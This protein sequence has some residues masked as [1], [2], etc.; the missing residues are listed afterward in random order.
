MEKKKQ[1][2]FSNE[3]RALLKKGI[4]KVADSVK[5]TLGAKGRNVIID[6]F[7]FP[8]VTKDGVT[9]AGEINLEHPIENMGARLIKQVAYQTANDSGDGTTT[10]TLL[11]QVVSTKG[12]QAIEDGANPIEVKKGMDKAVIEIVNTLREKSQDISADY[13]ILK[14]I[15]VISANGDEEIGHLVADVASRVRVDGLVT[16]EQS[17][18]NETYSEVVEGTKILSGYINPYYITNHAKM[19]CEYNDSVVFLYDGDLNTQKDFQPIIVEYEALKT[20]KP[21][22]IFTSGI[23]GEALSFFTINKVKGNLQN[24]PIRLHGKPHEKLELLKDIQS[25]TGGSIISQTTGLMMKDFNKTMFGSL[26]RIITDD[27][28][29]IITN[30]QNSVEKRIDEIKEQI[31]STKEDE[32]KLQQL[33]GRVA[34]LSGGVAVISVGGKTEAEML[35]RKD[36]IDDAVGATKAAMEEGIIAGGG[37]ALFRAKLLLPKVKLPNEDQQIGWDIVLN[38]LDAPIRQILT[39][40]GYYSERQEEII[41]KVGKEKFNFGFDI[42]NEEVVD[43][44]KK[45]IIDPFKVVRNCIE[46]STS[47]AGLIITTECV[48]NDK[49]E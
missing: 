1:I 22:V 8:H 3:G 26:D 30:E 42:L 15:A 32:F 33:R 18:T 27:K 29:T 37:V 5:V 2:T 4:D 39:N 24:I 41:N 21:L 49:E 19:R 11:A 6:R 38:S 34:R 14:Q 13:D 12:L 46:N 25:I 45:G 36:R 17:K 40:G 7:P 20:N 47:I 9:V 35:E 10:S 16:V 28:S 48:I 23:D 43:M 31:K 44:V